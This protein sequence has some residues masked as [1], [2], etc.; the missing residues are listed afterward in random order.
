VSGFCHFCL[1]YFLVLRQSPDTPVLSCLVCALFHVLSCAA[2]SLCFTLA[3]CFYVVMFCLNTW[4][5]SVLNSCV[6]MSRFVCAHGWWFVWHVWWA[7]GFSS[8]VSLCH[9]L[10]SPV[11]LSSPLKFNQEIWFE[12]CLFCT[13]W[14]SHTCELKKLPAYKKKLLANRSLCLITKYLIQ[15]FCQLVLFQLGH[16]SYVFETNWL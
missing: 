13:K 14:N 6:F 16:V 7:H 1:V 3:V 15:S 10:C 11:D 5:M 8:Y 2:R 12:M 4:L 9:V